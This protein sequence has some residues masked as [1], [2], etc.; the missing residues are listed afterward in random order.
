MAQRTF[1][2]H[3]W[4]AGY[5]AAT[6]AV[7]L[8]LVAVCSAEPHPAFTHAHHGPQAVHSLL[9]VWACQAASGEQIGAAEAVVAYQPLIF[10]VAPSHLTSLPSI[11]PTGCSSRAPPQSA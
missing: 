4:T 7:L 6:Y 3:I 10:L 8:L 2:I 9:C 11:D 1:R 5:L